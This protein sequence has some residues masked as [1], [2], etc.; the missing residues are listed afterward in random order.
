MSKIMFA[1]I[2]FLAA[3]SITAMVA[4][5]ESLKFRLNRRRLNHRKGTMKK[6]M[7]Q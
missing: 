7:N 3:L 4:E 5:M 2:L 1:S 6:Q